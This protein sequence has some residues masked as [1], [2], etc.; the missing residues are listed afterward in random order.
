MYYASINVKNLRDHTMDMFSD[1]QRYLP[2]ILTCGGRRHKHVRALDL[3]F[4]QRRP[5]RVLSSGIKRYVV[6]WKS[7]FRR[8]KWQ[9][10]ACCL[11]LAGFLLGLLI[12]PEGDMFLADIDW[13]SP[14]YLALYPWIYNSSYSCLSPRR[15]WSRLI[16]RNR[17]N[18]I[19]NNFGSWDYFHAVLELLFPLL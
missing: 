11:I 16:K 10:S 9:R 6:R 4:S 19:M 17:N 1:R 13:R 14:D 18:S 12:D 2:K 7:T 8:N 15:F 3:R 5:W